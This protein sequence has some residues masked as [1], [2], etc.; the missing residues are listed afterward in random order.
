MGKHPCAHLGSHIYSGLQVLSWHHQIFH[1]QKALKRQRLYITLSSPLTSSF[2]LCMCV[3]VSIIGHMPCLSSKK[4]LWEFFMSFSHTPTQH[5][6]RMVSGHSSLSDHMPNIFKHTYIRPNRQT[7]RRHGS[8]CMSEL[9]K[10]RII[11]S[12]LDLLHTV[13]RKPAGSSFYRA[14]PEAPFSYT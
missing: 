14:L 3:C 12:H 11:L 1:F 2:S 6:N 9:T 7:D 4:G 13:C 8:V 10:S 5:L